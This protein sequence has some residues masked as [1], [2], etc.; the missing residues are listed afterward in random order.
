MKHAFIMNSLE[1]VKAWKDTS[2]FLMLAAY[3]RGHE[4]AYLDQSD[5]YL[6][7]HQLMA[8][9]QWLK[10]TDSHEQPFEIISEERVNLSEADVIWLRTDPPFDRRYFYTT[11]LLDF[12]PESVK[13]VNRPDGV[14]DWNEKLSAIHFPEL[15]PRTLVSNKVGE[16]R[17]FAAQHERITLKP[18]DGFGGKGI[19]FYSPGKESDSLLEHATLKGAH[20]VIAQEYLPA[21]AQGDKR[22]LLINGE[23]IGAIL[24][25]HAQG[26]ELNNLDMGGQAVEADLD[27]DDLAICAALKPHLIKKGAFFVGID[28]IGGK[29][30]EINITSPTGLQ[31]LSRF[32]GLALHHNIIKALEP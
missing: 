5:L 6:D 27:E 17:H 26:E 16:I 31:E 28:I 10:V 4:V 1:G 25:V 13:V 2:Y 32:S 18:I 7:H 8:Q 30:I 29:L 9:L 3:E 23:P 20:W 12:L 15:T 22:I 14:R 24:R 19:V 21:A 11:L